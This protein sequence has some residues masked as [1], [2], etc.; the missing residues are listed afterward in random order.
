[1]KNVFVTRKIPEIGIEMLRNRGYSVDISSEDRPLSQEEL[2]DVLKSKSYDAVLTL[3]NDKIDSKVFDAS[4]NTKIFANFAIGYD[5]FDTVEAK[6]RGI[7]LTNTPGGGANRVSEHVWALILALSCRVVE[8]DKFVKAGKYVGWD[9]MLL[10]GTSVRGKVLGLIG[11]GKIGSEVARIGSQAFGM[12]VVYYDVK[13]N[14]E[15]ESICSCTYYPSAEEVI[16]QADYVSL[17][18]PLLDSTRHLMNAKNI[19]LMKKTAFLIN[20]SRGPVV[21]EKSLV[22]ALNNGDIAGA[23]LDVFE[24]E[25]NLSPGLVKF[26]N[27]ILTPHIASATKESRQDMAILSAKNIITTLEGGIP[28]N[29]VYN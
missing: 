4:P 22:Q 12:R 8:G 28:P 1:M 10:P 26:N 14:V 17:H 29:M 25:P 9:P 21:D 5:N 16:K 24:N 6:K 27:V 7:Y 19:S 3:L 2:I 15:L 18:V 13:R 11:A 23:G 20:T